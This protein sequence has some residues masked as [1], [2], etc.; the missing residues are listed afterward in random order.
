MGRHPKGMDLRVVRMRGRI[1]AIGEQLL[2]ARPTKT[3]GGQ[4]DGVDDDELGRYTIGAGVAV[5]GGSE[6]VLKHIR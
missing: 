1:E 6:N 3:V 4:A 5:G 2:D